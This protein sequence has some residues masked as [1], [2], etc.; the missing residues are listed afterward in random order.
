MVSPLRTPHTARVGEVDA[1]TDA[2]A[3][4]A[5]VERIRAGDDAAFEHVVRTYFTPLVRFGTT[6]LG[7]YDAAEDLAQEVLCRVWQQ[8]AAWQPQ[9]SI[10]AYLFAAVRNRA[11]NALEHRA[12]EERFEVE[13][14][15]A[16]ADAEGRHA[17]SAESARDDD[18][19]AVALRRAVRGLNARQ[20]D[21]LRLRYEERLTVPEVAR[22]LGVSV[23]A[24]ENVLARAVHALR[25]TMRDPSS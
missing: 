5:L 14:R 7:A 4:A 10:R 15:D 6:F 24:A 21:A 8:G 3:D 1:S 11:L 18:D 20:R 19:A 2:R 25:A 22:V 23:K 16:V 13:T 17:V 12:V 9:G